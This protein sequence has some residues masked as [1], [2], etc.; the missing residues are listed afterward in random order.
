MSFLRKR[1]DSNP[2]EQEHLT[3]NARIARFSIGSALNLIISVDFLAI[4]IASLVVIGTVGTTQMNLGG[5][6][7]ATSSCYLYSHCA[8]VTNVTGDCPGFNPGSSLVCNTA[9]VGFAFI[10]AMGLAFVI[11]L[12]IKAVLHQE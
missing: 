10:G 7:N 8:K 9:M 6:A 2:E 1:E 12:V 11:S 3:G 5:V 4:F